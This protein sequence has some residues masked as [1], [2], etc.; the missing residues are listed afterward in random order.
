[1]D[2]DGTGGPPVRIHVTITVKGDSLIADF[3]G[4]SPQ[5]RGAIN[6][7]DS[8]VQAVIAF[9]VRA[10]MREDVPNS[11]GLFNP[12]GIIAP[13]GSVVNVRMPGASSMR[14]ITGFRMIDAVFGAFAQMLP[15]RVYA[16]GE[17][18]NS[19]VIMGGSRADGSPFVYYELVSGTWGARPDRDGNDGLCNIASI[20]SNIPIEQAEVEY[21]V[22]IDR[23][24][25]VMDSG[26]PGRFRGGLAIEREWT[27]LAQEA[28]SD[29][30]LR[31]A[32]SPALRAAGRMPGKRF[33]QHPASCRWTGRR[34]CRR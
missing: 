28:Q 22:R 6:C 14:G 18:G 15:D 29:H 24:G 4:S 21:P 16:A 12:L 34:F 20:G 19:L 31:P 32:R 3:T 1:M 11:A 5:V 17:G 2:T 8:F 26:G 25:Y 27:L 30:S 9:C 13:E 10:L 7:T 23:Y 33:H